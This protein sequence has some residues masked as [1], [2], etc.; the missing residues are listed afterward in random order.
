MCASESLAFSLFLAII[1]KITAK[2][3]QPEAQNM[4]FNNSGL[5][6]FGDGSSRT[7]TPAGI[8]ICGLPRSGTT[9]LSK[10]FQE[11]GFSLGRELSNVLEDQEFRKCCLPF[12]NEQFSSYLKNRAKDSKNI[13]WVAKFPEF[14][15]DIHHLACSDEI[16]I[17]VCTRDP[18]AI[19]K[20]NNLSV[21]QDI[22]FLLEKAINEYS[23][24]IKIIFSAPS[25]DNICL[26]SYEKL[27]TSPD[28][29]FLQLFQWLSINDS[30]IKEYS[31]KAKKGIILN[32]PGYLAES[33]L[34]P[35]YSIDNFQRN[36]ISGWC[37]FQAAPGRRVRLELLHKNTCIHEFTCN[38]YRSDLISRIDHG[39]CGF[40]LKIPSTLTDDFPADY[41][42]RIK[43]TPHLLDIPRKINAK[44]KREQPPR[45]PEKT[46]DTSKTTTNVKS[47]NNR[48]ENKCDTKNKR[49][50]L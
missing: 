12:N 28:E 45:H 11:A 34:I 18:L 19:A 40:N 2:A 4:E 44:Q 29:L 14:Y 49:T 50:N 38:E 20:R 31:Q 46:I 36:K 1:R 33:N 10:C 27:L 37:Y 39:K 47:E 22:K 21:F 5:I 48:Q 42:L 26:L 3:R 16:A 13:P 32:S 15:K 43:G 17:I 35:R 9:G 41:S 6:T 8:I 25:L 30:E 7:A 24:M 23:D